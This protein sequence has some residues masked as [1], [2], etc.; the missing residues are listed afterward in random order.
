MVQRAPRRGQVWFGYTPGQPE[1]PHQPRPLLVVSDDTRNRI[2]DDVIV[3]PI[4]S[5]GRPGPT[6]VS[7]QAGLGGI[8]RD[9][10][11]F[12]EEISTISHDFL[13]H[14]PLGPRL[15][16]YVLRQV[17]RAVRRALGEVLPEP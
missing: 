16:G 13:E 11:L 10:M 12:C 1:D 2:A 4:F 14:G 8:R 3:V 7:L 15:P 6:R 5:R 17:S 9:S